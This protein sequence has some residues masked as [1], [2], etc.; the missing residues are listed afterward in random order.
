MQFLD[1]G[2]E[3]H[4]VPGAKTGKPEAR[5]HRNQ[6]VPCG[7]RTGYSVLSFSSSV[8]IAGQDGRGTSSI[9]GVDL[10]CRF[11]AAPREVL[12]TFV[13]HISNPGCGGVEVVVRHIGR[14]D[15]PVRV[16]LS[17]GL[18]RQRVYLI[19]GERPLSI[20]RHGAIDVIPHRRRQ[21]TSSRPPGSNREDLSSFRAGSR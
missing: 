4:R 6:E 1:F 8:E 10:R 13:D 5:D 2:V 16:G 15:L 18:G 11:T 14:R 21:A 17:K 3:G 9:L 20:K 12:R 19:G 7:L